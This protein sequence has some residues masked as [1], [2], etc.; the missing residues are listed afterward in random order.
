MNSHW[1]LARRLL[2]WRPEQRKINRSVLLSVAGVTVGSGVLVLSLSVLNGFEVLVHGSLRRFEQEL[3]ARPTTDGIDLEATITR[4]AETGWSAH[5]DL[6][7][8]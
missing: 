8:G 1:F 5:I 2:L 6:P 3:V 4:L 7:A